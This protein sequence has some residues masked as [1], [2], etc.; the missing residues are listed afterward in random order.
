MGSVSLLQSLHTARGPKVA[1][2]QVPS[3]KEALAALPTAAPAHSDSE[4]LR[5]S[6]G[7]AHRPV[8]TQQSNLRKAAGPGSLSARRRP[9]LGA[10]SACHRHPLRQTRRP[11]A[12]LAPRPHAGELAE[13]E[14]MHTGRQRSPGRADGLS[15]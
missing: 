15:S 3:R 6:Q 10:P 2:N 1:G 11:S 14:R 7:R 9:D 13:S 4:G 5:L 8:P 12:A